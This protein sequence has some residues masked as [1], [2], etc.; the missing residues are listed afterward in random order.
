MAQLSAKNVVA[1]AAAGARQDGAEHPAP[2]CLVL[3]V[4]ERLLLGKCPL[5]HR[6]LLSPGRRVVPLK[7]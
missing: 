4:A 7:L 2:H 5:P 1:E 3:L 6:H